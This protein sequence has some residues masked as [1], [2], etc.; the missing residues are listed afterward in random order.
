MLVCMCEHEPSNQCR[1]QYVTHDAMFHVA[2]TFSEEVALSL[3]K[4]NCIPCLLYGLEVCSIGT[5]EMNLL[6]F[7]VKRTVF[8]IVLTNSDDMLELSTF[9][10]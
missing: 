2:R 8:K 7:A 6:N 5:M 3:M 1:N 4:A 10:T 9:R